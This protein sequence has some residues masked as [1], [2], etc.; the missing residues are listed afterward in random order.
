MAEQLHLI[1]NISMAVAIALA[2]GLLAHRLRQSVIVGYLLAGIVIGPFSPG[3]VGDRGQIAA[4]AEV[5]VIFL[6][7]ALGVEFSLKELARVKAVALGGTALQ[8][9]LLM[10]AGLGLGA[11]LGWP[12]GQALFFGGILAISS[13]MVILKTLLDRGE[14]GSRHGRKLVPSAKTT[15]AIPSEPV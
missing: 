2:G 15:L 9:L 8:V 4:L 10:A 6:M 7:F 14:V 3:F 12:F 11:A 5:G 1:L 13:T